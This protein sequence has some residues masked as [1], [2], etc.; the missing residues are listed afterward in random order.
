[1]PREIKAV[2]Y[3]G[4]DGY[5]VYAIEDEPGLTDFYLGKAGCGVIEYCF[6]IPEQ[7]ARLT[8]AQYVEVCFAEY[9]PLLD[10]RLVD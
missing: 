6:G 10:E 8:D 4:P 5:Y 2:R 3:D 7:P 1:M 9:I